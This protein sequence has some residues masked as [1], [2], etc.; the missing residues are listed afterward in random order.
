[1]TLPPL[2]TEQNDLLPALQR[3]VRTLSADIGP[4]SVFA[5]DGLRQA[6]DYITSVWS[7]AG[8]QV[9]RQCFAVEIGSMPVP[10]ENIWVEIKGSAKPEEL[11][12]VGA[13]YDTVGEDVPG[14]NDNG[15]GVAALLELA[16]RLK[17]HPFQKSVRFV[18]F[19]NEEPPFFLGPEMGSMRYAAQAKEKGERIIGMVSLETIGYYTDDE[20]SQRYPA[21]L[22][23]KY[24]KQGNFLAFVSD[25]NSGPL[26][27]EAQR[28][29]SESTQFPCESLAAPFSMPGVDLSDHS[30]FWRYGYPALMV[31]DTALFRYPHY[32]EVTD[33]WE[34]LNYDCYARVVSGLCGMIAGLAGAGDGGAR[35][36]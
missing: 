20:E 34:K 1:M 4:R 19:V 21:P 32:H 31:T 11:L 15:S 13:H 14:A 8:L 22:S 24:P 33:T 6:A 26:L 29:F 9:E 23:L 12:I 16:L 10:V 17:T 25:L 28:H 35:G 30:S 36:K 27:R 3:H 2:E 7:D 18:A 5:Y